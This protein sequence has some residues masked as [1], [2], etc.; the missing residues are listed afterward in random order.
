MASKGERIG[1]AKNYKITILLREKTF[2]SQQINCLQIMVTTI[3][4]PLDAHYLLRKKRLYVVT[5]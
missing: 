2:A 5:C 3:N 4:Y 1:F